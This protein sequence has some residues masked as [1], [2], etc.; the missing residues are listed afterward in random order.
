VR[1]EIGADGANNKPE[2]MTMTED[3]IRLEI[4]ARVQ[5]V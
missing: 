1:R 3:E 4:N 2:E 5:T